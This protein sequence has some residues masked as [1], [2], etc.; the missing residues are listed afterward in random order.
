MEPIV[1]MWPILLSLF[2]ILVIENLKNHFIF[3][4]LHFLV[5][6]FLFWKK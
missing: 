5:L 3:A 6:I 2:Q 4:F 1:K